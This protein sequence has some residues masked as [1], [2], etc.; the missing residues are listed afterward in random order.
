M[1][2]GI[3]IHA[4]PRVLYRQLWWIALPLSVTLATFL[5]FNVRPAREGIVDPAMATLTPRQRLWAAMATGVAPALSSF[6]A[7]L[8]MTIQSTRM[9]RTVRSV[10]GL[11][12]ERCL[13]DLRGTPTPGACPECGTP[14]E[15]GALRE[16]WIAVRFLKVPPAK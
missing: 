10:E 15:A 8:A 1:K 5:L 13:H 16:K 9:S 12:C 7:L 4:W 14:F 6:V 11:A 2:L 3:T